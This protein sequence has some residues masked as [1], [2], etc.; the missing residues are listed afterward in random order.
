MNFDSEYTNDGFF[1]DA[2]LGDETPIDY[3]DGGETAD[4]GDELD[5]EQFGF[6]KIVVAGIGGGGCNAV[7]N[8]IECSEKEQGQGIGKAEFVVMNTDMMALRMSKARTKLQLGAKITRGLGAGSDPAVGREAALAS[9]ADIKRVLNGTNLLFITAGMGGGTGTGAAPIVAKIAQQMGIL[10]V[11]VV[12]KPFEFEASKRMRNA[13]EGI[14]ELRK[15]VD[16]MLVIPNQKLCQLRGASDREISIKEAFDIADRV[17]YQAVKGVSDIITRPQVI[18]LDFADVKTV[19]KDKGLAHMGIG[20]GDGEDRIAQAIKQAIY[21]PLLETSIEGATSLIINFEG[22]DNMSM[23]EINDACELVRPVLSPDVNIIFG[24][25]NVKGKRDVTITV[26][27]TGFGTKE[28]IATAAPSLQAPAQR[29]S[30]RDALVAA[31]TQPQQPYANLE[32]IHFVQPRP[33]PQQLPQA[34]PI[35]N[36]TLPEPEPQLPPQQQQ[37]IRETRFENPQSIAPS[38]VDVS[39]RTVPHFLRRLRDNN[40]NQ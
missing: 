19:L 3:S 32:E 5:E 10:T 35:Y 33:I 14:S 6:A 9:E 36:S 24:M 8:M 18:N 4:D 21:S 26:I 31:D 38:R 16:T 20:Y 13:E 1:G 27:A 39:S 11:G 34:R 30:M 28:G 40:D 22:G 15:Y 17:L 7:N 23:K 29:R 25:N 37:P 12:T 2:D